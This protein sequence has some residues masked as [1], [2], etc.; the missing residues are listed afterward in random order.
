[1]IATEPLTDSQISEIGLVID[2]HLMMAGTSLS[3]DNEPQITESFGGQGNPPY[4]YGSRIDSAVES[5]LYSHE[6]VW[7]NRE[8]FRS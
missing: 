3:T 6:V 4:L 5:N 2:L 1:M 7:E 8:F